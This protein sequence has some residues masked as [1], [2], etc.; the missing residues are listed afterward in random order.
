M[1][2]FLLSL[3]R[4]RFELYSEPP[5][6]PLVAPAPESGRLRRWA[7]S[8]NVRWRGLVE[9]A[10]EATATGTFGRWRDRIVCHLAEKIAEQR[11]L[12]ALGDRTEATLLYPSTL[13]EAEARA[14]LSKVVAAAARH[15][16]WWLLVDVLVFVASAILAPI[17]GP[18]MV[19]YYVAFRI[20]GHLQSWRG[21]RRAATIA[22]TLR[23]DTNLDEL[24]ELAALPRAARGS[25]VD[26][27]AARLH[28]QRLAKFFERVAV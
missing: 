2:L 28:L 3:G 1:L 21:A 16:G 12:W 19:A 26:A 4:N 8:A 24:A 11:T 5:D 14:T 6:D 23:P 10:R 20:V 15:H 17:P 25:R 7:H 9:Q 18:N 13:V 27:I 22:W